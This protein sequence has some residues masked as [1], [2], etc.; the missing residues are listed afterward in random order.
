MGVNLEDAGPRAAWAVL[1]LRTPT[2]PPATTT[3]T[4]LVDGWVVDPATPFRDARATLLEAV[5][6]R[7]A[8]G[9]VLTHHHPDHVGAAT[10]LAA[11]IGIPIAAHP[12]TAELLADRVRVDV[13]LTDGQALG[14]TDWEVLHTPGHASGHIVLHHAATA[15]LIV[16]DMVASTGTI[17]I[18]P[19]DGHMATYLA[20]L[21][22]LRALAPRV[23]VPAHGAVIEAASGSASGATPD[24]VL[25]FYI[26]HREARRAL[27]LG[28]LGARPDD[29]GA[30]TARAYPELAPAL[31]P[32]ARRSALAH[33]I[34]LAEDGRA[35][36]EGEPGTEATWRR[37]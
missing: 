1:P 18:D 31:L 25:G 11:E 33:L 23:L 27:V 22:R 32:L 8:D 2:L 9:I 21:R 5:R 17:V 28:A 13:T 29:L 12:R 35:I 10:W 14:G 30:I 24:A 37:A 7:G 6:R 20:Q 15:R 19:P 16:G 26:Q 34:E 4:T 36:A 3:N